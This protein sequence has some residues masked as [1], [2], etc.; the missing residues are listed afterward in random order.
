MVKLDHFL[1]S[2]IYHCPVTGRQNGDEALLSI[3]LAGRGILVKMLIITKPHYIFLSILH[4]Y[5]F[6]HW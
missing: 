1:Y 3:I 2:F 6:Y 5:P 4:S